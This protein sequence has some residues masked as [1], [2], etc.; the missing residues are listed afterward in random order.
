MTYCIVGLNILLSDNCFFYKSNIF[1]SIHHNMNVAKIINIYVTLLSLAYRSGSFL[2]LTSEYIYMTIIG[3]I[4]TNKALYLNAAA[5]SRCSI[6]CMARCEPHPGHFNPVRTR[7]GHFG[8][9]GFSSGLNAKNI[10][11]TDIRA[12]IK[13]A[14]FIYDTLVLRKMLSFLL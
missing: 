5:K 1:L 6:E 14:F 2:R 11:P 3:S 12:D 4:A 13:N 8:N 10:T 7:K 9:I